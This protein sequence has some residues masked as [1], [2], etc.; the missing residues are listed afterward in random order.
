MM[1]EPGSKPSTALKCCKQ[2]NVQYREENCKIASG[3]NP[4][5][6]VAHTLERSL[7][8]GHSG[9]EAYCSQYW[10]RLTIHCQHI[11]YAKNNGR[12]TKQLPVGETELHAE[13]HREIHGHACKGGVKQEKYVLNHEV[14]GTTDAIQCTE[15]NTS[16]ELKAKGGQHVHP[17][18]DT[19]RYP[20]F[21]H[22]HGKAHAGRRTAGTLHEKFCQLSHCTLLLNDTFYIITTLQLVNITVRVELDAYGNTLFYFHKIASGIVD[23]NK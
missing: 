14:G 19:T 1:Y 22:R 13:K 21:H 12:T 20:P 2:D 3:S 6:D 7:Y 4:K 16:A 18:L 9:N 5:L 15:I 23:R 8:L 10:H 11:A 17:G